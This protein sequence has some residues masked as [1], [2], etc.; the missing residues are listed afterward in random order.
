MTRAESRPSQE[1]DVVARAIAEHFAKS[2]GA[3]IE[4]DGYGVIVNLPPIASFRFN[5]SNVA[6]AALDA[7]SEQEEG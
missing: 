7:L 6:R 5:A 4:D 1:G 3:H 2:F